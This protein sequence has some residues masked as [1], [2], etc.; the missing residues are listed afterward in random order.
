MKDKRPKIKF[1]LSFVL[2][3]VTTVTAPKLVR[4]SPPPSSFAV[5]IAQRLFDAMTQANLDDTAL[6]AAHAEDEDPETWTLKQHW[7]AVAALSIVCIEQEV[8]IDS[9]FPKTHRSN[10][11]RCDNGGVVSIP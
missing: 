9:S 4:D 10:C 8:H 6:I 3:F 5:E 7:E 1:Y 2:S 11:S